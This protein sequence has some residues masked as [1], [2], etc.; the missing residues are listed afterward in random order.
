[1]FPADHHPLDGPERVLMEA[2]KLGTTEAEAFAYVRRIKPV[3]VEKTHRFALPQIIKFLE[4]R[5]K[6]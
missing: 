3:A 4:S 2:P 1:V 6:S 5:G